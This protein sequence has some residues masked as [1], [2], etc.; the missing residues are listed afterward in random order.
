MHAVHCTQNASRSK[1]IHAQQSIVTE[2]RRR[3]LATTRE[4]KAFA[5]ATAGDTLHDA[6]VS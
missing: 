1:T 2:S 6:D 3:G 5:F 4:H